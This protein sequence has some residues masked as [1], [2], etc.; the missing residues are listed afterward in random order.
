LALDATGRLLDVG[1]GPGILTVKLASH[2]AEAIGLDADRE[3][4]TEADTCARV[5]GLTNVRWVHARAEELPLDLGAFNV[6]SF[7]QSFHWLD[8]E[9]VAAIVLE[10]LLPG[11]ALVYVSDVK[12]A[13]EDRHE[14]PNPTPP[15]AEI[16]ALVHRYLGPVRRA[17]QS[18]CR[19]SSPN[20]EEEVLARAGYAG[21]E[22]LRVPADGPLTRQSDDVVAWV[23]SLS[24]SAPHLFGEELGRFE[25]DLRRL[26]DERSPSGWFADQ[27]TDTDVRI[28]RTQRN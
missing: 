16:T 8:R 15:Y 22:R 2:F 18:L 5:A 25:T 20:D 4:L 12:E 1:C 24:S 6:V 27:P 26:L 21:P 10:M 19:Q 11:G 13:A 14:L 17:G 3:M 7:G 23:F 28:W 9:R